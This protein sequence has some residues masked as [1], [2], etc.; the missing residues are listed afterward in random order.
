MVVSM[1]YEICMTMNGVLSFLEWEN[2][3]ILVGYFIT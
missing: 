1:E 3:F 2:H